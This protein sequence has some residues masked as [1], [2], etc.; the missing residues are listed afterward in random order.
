MRL[1]P[2]TTN[3]PFEPKKP[4]RVKGAVQLQM[5]EGSKMQYLHYRGCV[6]TL[7]VYFP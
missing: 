3:R 7:Q 1:L 4:R 6:G 2:A 5:E